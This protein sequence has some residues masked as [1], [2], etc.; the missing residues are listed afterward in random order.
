MKIETP[1]KM[2][3]IG[4][5]SY[6]ILQKT[7]QFMRFLFILVLTVYLVF[8]LLTLVD[9]L[10]LM[11]KGDSF[12]LTF[13]QMRDFLTDAL[14]VLIVID[15][16]SAMFYQKRIHYVLS[17]LEIGFIVVT[18]KLILLSPEPQNAHLI[19]VLTF[20]SALFFVLIFYFYK[21][22]GRLRKA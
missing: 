17:L 14:F 12:F 8:C 10:F 19:F 6:K 1:D 20:A 18:R 16:I 21:V 3:L 22:T 15:F 7:V 13:T 5:R 11:V 4:T 2:E 9:R